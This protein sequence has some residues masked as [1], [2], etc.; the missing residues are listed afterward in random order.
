MVT[1]SMP[2]KRTKK[3][4]SAKKARPVPPRRPVTSPRKPAVPSV[5]PKQD[6]LATARLA[7]IVESSDD[8]IVGK[9]LKGVVTSWNHSAERLFGYTAKEMIGKSITTLYPQDRLEEEARILKSIQRGER[10]EHFETVRRR[11]NGGLVDVSV[12]VSPIKDGNGHVIGASKIVRDITERKR[13]EAA[14]RKSEQRFRAIYDQTYE[15]IGLLNPDGTMIDA[16]QTA[17]AFRELQLS[18]VVGKP[19]WST[20]WWDISPELQERVKAGIRQASEGTFV[21]L[22]AQHRA[23]DGTVEEIDF[24]LTPITNQAGQVTEILPEGRRITPITNALGELRRTQAELES[25]VQERTRELEKANAVLLEN[26]REL[27]R[28]QQRLQNLASKL[29]VAQEDERRRIARELHDD[30]TQRLAALTI[31]LQSLHPGS[32][33]SADSLS[34]CLKQLGDTAERLTTDLQRLAHHLHPSILEHV[35]LE[36]AVREHAEDFQARTSLKTEIMVRT[37]PNNIPPDH[38]TCLYRVLQESLQNVRKHANATSVLIRLMRTGRGV[39]LC[40][41]DDGRGFEN[42]PEP[43]KRTG[44]GLTSMAER[45][46]AL[47]GTF[48]VRTKPGDGTEVHAWVP[49]EQGEE[50]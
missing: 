13:A 6:E 5:T 18:D 2:P 42:S 22:H 32:C 3:T 39:G 35:G 43:T 37:L 27:Q 19:F 25:R 26:Q 40:I 23:L 11:K 16:N 50:R 12:T 24:S 48:R 31:D 38:A 21:R 44:L 4:S 47:Q 29:L 28:Q 46:G 9:D 15:F 10:I 34:M 49:L 36:A 30:V 17:L 45:V 7:A 1:T 14:L 33:E 41:H 8:A 20:P